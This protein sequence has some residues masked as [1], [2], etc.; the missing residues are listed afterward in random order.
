MEGKGREGMRNRI[1]RRIM[2][3]QVGSSLPYICVGCG[4]GIEEQNGSGNH[5]IH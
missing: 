5:D 2:W 1:A 3:Y 4:G